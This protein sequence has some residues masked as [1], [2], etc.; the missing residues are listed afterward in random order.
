MAIFNCTYV[1]Q[2]AH[3]TQVHCT[4]ARSTARHPSP[5]SLI[6]RHPHVT[7]TPAAT[8]TSPARQPHVSR[9]SAAR[10]LSQP[11]FPHAACAFL[12]F[13]RVATPS[14]RGHKTPRGFARTPRRNQ[15]LAEERN[16]AAT[17]RWARFPR[18]P[19]HSH[20]STPQHTPAHSRYVVP[21]P[22]HFPQ[23]LQCFPQH[24]ASFDPPPLLT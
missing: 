17:R 14:M 2:V 6:A 4:S 16:V 15:R 22:P 19:C 20:P 12:Q 3:V 23:T 13:F 8:R 7:R 11:H 9:T 21:T 5:S 10:H 18:I 1:T 24:T